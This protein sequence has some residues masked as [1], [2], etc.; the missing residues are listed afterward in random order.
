MYRR[1]FFQENIFTY[2]RK[3]N[4]P[5][6]IYSDPRQYECVFTETIL[7]SDKYVLVYKM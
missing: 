6:H 2:N 7:L 3:K 1:I 4:L 5:G